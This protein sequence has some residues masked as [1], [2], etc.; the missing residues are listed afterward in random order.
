[1]GADLL[2]RHIGDNGTVGDLRLQLREFISNLIELHVHPSSGSGE[3]SWHEKSIQL[4]S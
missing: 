4:S 3:N 2:R 1:M